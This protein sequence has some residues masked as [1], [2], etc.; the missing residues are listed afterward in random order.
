VALAF[1][2][3]SGVKL[4]A[5]NPELQRYMMMAILVAAGPALAYLR[6]YR[7]RL[8]ADEGLVRER[9]G[10]PEPATR[11][12]LMKSLVI[13]GALCELPMAIGVLQL[14]LGGETRWFLGA[15]LVTIAVR[16]SYRPFTR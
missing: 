11:A 2:K 1:V 13:G 10:I 12:A 16:L 3:A 9:G 5:L 14:L 8:I 4:A 7:R 15:T 6:T